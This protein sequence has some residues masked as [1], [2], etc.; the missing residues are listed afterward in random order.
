MEPGGVAGFFQGER[1]YSPRTKKNSGIP[2]SKMVRDR[3]RADS[4]R[5]SR[6]AATADTGR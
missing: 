4:S 3:T 5:Q 1:A 2:I 6:T